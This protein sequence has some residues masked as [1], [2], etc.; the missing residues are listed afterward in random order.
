MTTRLGFAI[1]TVNSYAS[2]GSPTN[3]VGPMPRGFPR[4]HN[5]VMLFFAENRVRMVHHKSDSANDTR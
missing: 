1:R 4:M 2:M 5:S 3:M